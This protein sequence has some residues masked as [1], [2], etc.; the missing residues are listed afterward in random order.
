LSL[1]NRVA[2][3][4]A[5][6]AI[7][8]RG[9]LMGNRGGRFHDAMTRDIGTRR[10]VTRQ[11]ICCVTVFRGRQRQV[12]GPNTYT[13]LFFCDEVTALAAG[14]RPCMECRRAD[15]LAYRQSVVNS[16]TA[17]DAPSFP[18]PPRS[19]GE[20]Q[21]GGWL[22]QKPLFGI[23]SPPDV[24]KLTDSTRSN[25]PP[26]LSL[27]IT[28]WGEGKSGRC[29][30][31]AAPLVSAVARLMPCP[32]LDRQLDGERR[33]GHTKRI[34]ELEADTLPDGVMV[35]AE[36]GGFFALK[37]NKALP[38]SPTGYG[39]HTARPKGRLQVLTPPTSIAALRAGYRP[40][41]HPTAG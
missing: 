3:D 5:L 22:Q 23:H 32:A 7:P 24:R 34:H 17:N 8:E 38:W 25:H 27:P 15:A 26:P 9:L 20:G 36:K 30:S 4:G 10:W 6:F 16:S 28:A 37:G 14:H 2:P 31:M 41:W 40:F 13:E 1:P 11:W 35:I 33:D 29:D 39:A 18:L 21:G 19:G 12:W